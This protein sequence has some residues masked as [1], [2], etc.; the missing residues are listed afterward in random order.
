M[1]PNS[2][3]AKYSNEV[4]EQNYDIYFF[5]V[6]FLRLCLSKYEKGWCRSLISCE[7]GTTSELSFPV[8]THHITVNDPMPASDNSI[9]TFLIT[10]N[11]RNT[12]ELIVAKLACVEL[13]PIKKLVE[14]PC[15][16]F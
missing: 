15:M 12:F 7:A 4:M 9:E 3:K 1:D 6:Y 10:I 16:K 2:K 8:K 5:D 13:M 14:S 11:S